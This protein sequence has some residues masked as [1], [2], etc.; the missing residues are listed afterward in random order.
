LRHGSTNI[1]IFYWLILGFQ[2]FL[3]ADFRVSVKHGEFSEEEFDK[4]LSFEWQY[5]LH[6][7]D[8]LAQKSAN[9]SY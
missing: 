9:E 3:L 7:L 4:F 6:E 5:H 2:D 1:K 8:E